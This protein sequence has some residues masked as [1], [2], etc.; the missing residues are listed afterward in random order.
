MKKDQ[1]PEK[2]ICPKCLTKMIDKEQI[3]N[4]CQAYKNM[5][6]AEAKYLQAKEKYYQT[7]V[8]KQDNTNIIYGSHTQAPPG[9]LDISDV[10]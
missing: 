6:I 1:K 2:K 7:R 10:Q 4:K 5:V 3:K 9:S 8:P